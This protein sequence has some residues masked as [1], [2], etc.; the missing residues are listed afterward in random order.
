L[1]DS[2]LENTMRLG[3]AG[4]NDL[5]AAEG[6]YHN[7]CLNAF[8]YDTQK[9]KKECETIDLAMIFLVQEL[10]YAAS[11]NQIFQLSHVW[12]RYF[13]LVAQTNGD[14]SQSFISRRT[15]FNEY[16]QNRL[17]DEYQ[18]LRPL[19]R[20][21]CERK[22]LLIPHTYSQHVLGE[23]HYQRANYDPKDNFFLQLV[24]VALKIRGDLIG[25]DG[26]VGLSVSEDD[27]IN[28]VPDRL[29]TFLNLVYGGQDIWNQDGNP[30]DSKSTKWT[31]KH[32]GLSCTLH[33]MTRS[34]QL[35]DL[36]HTAGHTL[37]HHDVLKIDTGLAEKSL[38]L[39]DVNT[40]CFVP[41]NLK[42]KVFTHFTA[43]NID[44]NDSTLDGKN[45]Y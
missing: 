16:L 8:K 31:P 4:V 6:K 12:E 5:I 23:L 15:T 29:F 10:E 17:G 45:R 38:E 11:K 27:A 32:I 36:L 1:Q 2:K 14:I 33:Q 40:G 30:E 41:H 19:Y 3:L 7:K 13:S 43:D 44:I 42:D 35:V 28:C 39:L 24:H 25:M 22:T 34:K 20:S 21:I 18:F 9:T 26:H 37:N